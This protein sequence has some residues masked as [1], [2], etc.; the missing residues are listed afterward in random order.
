MLENVNPKV[1]NVMIGIKKPY[2]IKI[3]PLSVS[4]ELQ[5]V[6]ILRDSTASLYTGGTEAEFLESIFSAISR[7]IETLIFLVVDK[8]EWEANFPD[9]DSKPDIFK[10]IDND[11]LITIAEIIYEVNFVEL[12]KKASGVMSK[13]GLDK[14]KKKFWTRGMGTKSDSSPDSFDITH[15]IDSAISSENDSETEDSQNV[16]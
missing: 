6:E 9:V 5:F 15:N 14:P 8:D 10:H 13:M 3:Y 11:Q 7:N 1:K 4:D 12:I 2:Q 16:N